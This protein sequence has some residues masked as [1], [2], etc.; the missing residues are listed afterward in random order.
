[1]AAESDSSNASNVV[2]AIDEVQR[3]A[4]ELTKTYFRHARDTY[5]TFVGDLL[6]AMEIHDCLEQCE[7][8]RKA[9]RASSHALTANISPLSPA[10]DAAAETKSALGTAQR[11]T[12]E[13]AS[14]WKEALGAARTEVGITVRGLVLR[15]YRQRLSGRAALT[16]Y[17]L[18]EAVFVA[19]QAV[20]QVEKLLDSPNPAP[21]PTTS[22]PTRLRTGL[23]SGVLAAAVTVLPSAHRERYREEWRA[24][25]LDLP[26]IRRLPHSIRLLLGAPSTSRILRH[27]GKPDVATED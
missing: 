10:A 1:M 11:A 4:N 12:D 2:D 3:L 21:S 20:A 26:K 23:T 15:A 14:M 5:K 27:D 24:E 17:G 22:G 8:L 18:N 16:A 9:I 25:L 7:R 19:R 6:I 13:L